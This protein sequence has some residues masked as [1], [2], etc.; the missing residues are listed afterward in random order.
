MF[1][2]FLLPQEHGKHRCSR[3]W[4]TSEDNAD[5]PSAVYGQFRVMC[6]FDNCAPSNC[7]DTC[8]TRNLVLEK[9]GCAEKRTVWMLQYIGWPETGVPKDPENFLGELWAQN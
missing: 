4:P 8:I 2:A 6:R 7:A 3:Y 5:I 1:I 9:E